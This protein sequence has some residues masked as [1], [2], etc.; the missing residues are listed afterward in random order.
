MAAE[1]KPES[2]FVWFTLA[3][4]QART[5]RAGRAVESLERAIEAG[6]SDAALLEEHADLE[7]L[8]DEEGFRRLLPVLEGSRGAEGP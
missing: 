4:A 1:I 8:R 7:V 3:R 5:G 6:F 2:P